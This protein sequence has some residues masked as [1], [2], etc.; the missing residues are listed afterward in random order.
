MLGGM[1]V[2]VNETV[3]FVLVWGRAPRESALSEIE[4]S[5]PHAARLHLEPQHR[6]DNARLGKIIALKIPPAASGKP[7]ADFP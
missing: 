5:K 1:K 7:Q 6:N 4:G 3:Q 2:Q